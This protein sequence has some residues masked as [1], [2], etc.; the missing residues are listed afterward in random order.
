[1]HK[2]KSTI[3]LNTQIHSKRTAPTDGPYTTP[4]AHYTC[5]H[6]TQ[7]AWLFGKVKSL[8]VDITGHSED[9]LEYSEGLDCHQNGCTL[10]SLYLSFSTFHSKLR[11]SEWWSTVFDLN[12]WPF[13]NEHEL[14]CFLNKTF[15]SKLTPKK[16]GKKNLRHFCLFAF[17]FKV[18]LNG[19][20]NS[21]QFSVVLLR[22]KRSCMHIANQG[23]LD[24]P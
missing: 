8:C 3:L 7:M 11:C 4:P 6:F 10:T 5:R 19:S 14:L 20:L 22:R 9:L 16:R 17:V 2:I 15:P 24:L 13:T 12:P 21:T 23:Q 1:M 18:K